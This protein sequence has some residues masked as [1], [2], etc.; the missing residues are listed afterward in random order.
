M[1]QQRQ[2]EGGELGQCLPEHILG[3]RRE[4]GDTRVDEER[5]ETANPLSGQRLDLVHRIGGEP[6]PEGDV[7]GALARG[8]T[9][10][11]RE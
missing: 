7:H 10:L 5:L 2:T 1:D 4:L 3:H 6:T 8:G 9:T 11:G